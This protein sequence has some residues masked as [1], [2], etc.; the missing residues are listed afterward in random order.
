MAEYKNGILKTYENN[1][2]SLSCHADIKIKDGVIEDIHYRGIPRTEGRDSWF[3][4]YKSFKRGQ[5]I[6]SAMVENLLFYNGRNNII[7]VFEEA[8]ND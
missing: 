2:M 1:C 3:A 7:S 5:E 4:I 8:N 6:S